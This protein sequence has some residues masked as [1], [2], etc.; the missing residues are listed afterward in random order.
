MCNTLKN[1][2]RSPLESV[3]K[4][5]RAAAVYC[6]DGRYGTHFDDFL[7]QGLGL[8]HYDLVVLPGGP[9]CLAGH[10][11][12]DLEAAEVIGELKFLADAHKL[13]RLVL[14]QH[15]GCAYYSHR[16]GVGPEQVIALQRADLVRVAFQIRRVSAN[17]KIEGYFAR[18]DGERLVFE[19]VALV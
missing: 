5:I 13:E 15:E 18:L 6:S 2:Y 10:T 12:A 14:I 7:Q 9:G 1:G 3:S 8:P 4:P 11:E 16:V 17:L 19:A